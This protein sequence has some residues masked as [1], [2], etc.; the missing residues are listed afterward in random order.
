MKKLLIQG[1]LAATFALF[2]TV[3]VSAQS[4]TR[5][6]VNIPFD[7]Q[8]HG[9]NYAAG[10]YLIGPLDSVVNKSSLAIRSVESRKTRLLGF[11]TLVGG[12]RPGNGKMVFAKADGLYT[13]AEI[14]T[15][16]FA[17]KIDPTKGNYGIGKVGASMP[18]VVSLNLN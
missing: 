17:L 6:R 2:V 1:L 12:V 4:A 13:L 16:S 11:T 5:Y 7:F 8:A 14:S 15:P 18:E 3:F 9:V 10:D